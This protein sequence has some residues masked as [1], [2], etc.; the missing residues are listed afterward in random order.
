MWFVEREG[1]LWLEA[2]TP[3]NPWFVDVGRDPRLGFQSDGRVGRFVARA[4]PEQS[5]AVRDALS[6]KYGLRDRWVGLFVDASRSVAVRLDPSV[7]GP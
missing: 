5:R 7:E 6:A 4:V 1:V 3:E 2:G